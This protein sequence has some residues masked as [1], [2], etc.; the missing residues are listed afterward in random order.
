MFFNMLPM[1]AMQW[2]GNQLFEHMT[3]RRIDPEPAIDR[4]VEEGRIDPFEAEGWSMGDC[5][6][7][8]VVSIKRTVTS[9]LGH[10]KTEYLLDLSTRRDMLET[11]DMPDACRFASSDITEVTVDGA[12]APPHIHNRRRNWTRWLRLGY[13]R[14]GSRDNL[15][16]F[17]FYEN[18][19]DSALY[20]G[21]I[22]S[23]DVDYLIKHLR[24]TE[25]A[26][27]EIEV[28]VYKSAFYMDGA[29]VSPLTDVPDYN[30]PDPDEV[31]EKKAARNRA[32]RDR[33]K[34]RKR[35]LAAEKA[36]AEAERERQRKENDDGIEGIHKGK[37]GHQQLA[38]EEAAR[39]RKELAESHREWERLHPK[40][41]RITVRGDSHKETPKAPNPDPT[42]EEI[43][44]RMDFEEKRGDRHAQAEKKKAD[45]H[46]DKLRR[47]AEA[48]EKA[49]REMVKQ[50]GMRIA[51]AANPKVPPMTF[52]RK[53]GL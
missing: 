37:K 26:D 23:D 21:N 41:E 29:M 7:A 15:Y 52:A 47:D 28:A 4:L 22:T 24:A 25:T 33:R 38:E 42:I 18:W 45:A 46:A 2:S 36:E 30:A 9:C 1:E 20:A 32:K 49:E 5:M 31:L 19:V 40:S 12:G 39:R 10:K 35:E 3:G 53:A 44:A 34:Q 27:S 14:N 48:K 16:A 50:A 17:I 43:I 8:T 6:D 11:I 51:E 13:D